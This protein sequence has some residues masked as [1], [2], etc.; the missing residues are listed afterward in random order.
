MEKTS[1]FSSL[2]SLSSVLSSACQVWNSLTATLSPHYA[3]GG[4]LSRFLPKIFPGKSQK[5]VSVLLNSRG[6]ISDPPRHSFGLSSVCRQNR[7]LLQSFCT[8]T[9]IHLR[10]NTSQSHL[11][12]I[13]S[14]VSEEFRC[15][16]NLV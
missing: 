14:Q 1:S 3:N 10:G 7:P 4:A 15:C 11:L 9:N 12:K 2:A 8:A 16:L 5:P 13:T 6:H